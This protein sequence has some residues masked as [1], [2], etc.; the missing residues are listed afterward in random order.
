MPNKGNVNTESFLKLTE[1]L[2][3]W[4]CIQH[5]QTTPQKPEKTEY[6]ETTGW[7]RR[8]WFY[9]SQIQ[10]CLTWS[11][12]EACRSQGH[13]TGVPC[14]AQGVVPWLFG[15]CSISAGVGWATEPLNQTSRKSLPSTCRDV[16]WRWKGWRCTPWAQAHTGDGFWRGWERGEGGGSRTEAAL[17]Q[18]DGNVVQWKAKC[19]RLE[20]Y[21]HLHN[22]LPWALH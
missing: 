17:A 12:R 10:D 19:M 9:K 21:P 22:G 7:K 13:H 5:G 15:P 8:D 11:M 18:I 1:L 14:K 3:P 4:C 6:G 16:P 20:L 2:A